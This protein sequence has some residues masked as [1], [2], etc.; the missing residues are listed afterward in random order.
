MAIAFNTNIVIKCKY[1]TSQKY[2]SS[3]SWTGWQMC[4]LSNYHYIVRLNEYRCHKYVLYIY[5]DWKLWT[6]WKFQNGFCVIRVCYRRHWTKIQVYRCMIMRCLVLIIDF[7]LKK[8]IE[9]PESA[10][11]I[12][13]PLIWPRNKLI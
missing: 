2:K 1:F 4:E 7:N 12:N 6:N 10:F 3:H 11:V 13:I 5:F 9:L 8:M